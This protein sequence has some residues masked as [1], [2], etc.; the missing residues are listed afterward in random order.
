MHSQT[1][2]WYGVKLLY[3]NKVVGE[4]DINLL[5]HNYIKGYVAYEESVVVIQADTF[6]S[7]YQ[8]AEQFAK[9]NQDDYQNIYGQTIQYRYYDAVD[10]Y[11]I[12][13]TQELQLQNGLEVYSRLIESNITEDPKAFLGRLYPI[14][15]GPKYMLL[16]SEFSSSDSGK[17]P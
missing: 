15:D 13:E 17:S 1:L 16:N 11:L 2:N 9:G 3:V 6:D 7:A 10:C 4:P 14:L 8:R 12:D 5:D